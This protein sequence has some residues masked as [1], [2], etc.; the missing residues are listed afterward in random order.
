MTSFTIEA[1]A[2]ARA[3]NYIKGSIPTRTT[4]PILQHVEIEAKGSTVTVRGTD[5]TMEAR[6]T[7]PADIDNPGLITVPGAMLATMISRLPSG[8][9]VRMQ[10]EDDGRASVVSGRSRYMLRTLPGDDFP[11]PRKME[12]GA[13]RWSM[14]GTDLA[15][16]LAATRTAVASGTDLSYLAG[17]LIHYHRPDN[18][19]SHMTAVATDR[20]RL[21]RWS[22]DAPK[23]SEDI[24]PNTVIPTEALRNIEALC[25]AEGDVSCAVDGVRFEVSS[26]NTTFSTALVSSEYPDYVRVIPRLGAPTF[27]VSADD[28]CEAI[29]RA[30]IVQS[31]DVVGSLTLTVSNGALVI[32]TAT[33]RGDA[34]REEVKHHGGEDGSTV[35]VNGKYLREAMA[36]WGEGVVCVQHQGSTAPI[37][38]TSNSNPRMTQVVMPFSR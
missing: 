32:E 6:A 34:G 31:G 21:V 15:A 27:E 3:L 13:A 18:A 23:G 12:N 26:G 35:K 1:G 14:A 9:D 30:M 4:I 25:D 10:I 17:V 37:L 24:P 5:L 33:T 28:L 19:A 38:I 16:M 11:A 29:D 36:L 8:G 20:H 2:F 22:V 7:V